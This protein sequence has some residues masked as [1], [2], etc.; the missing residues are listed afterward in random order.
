[1]KKT[2]WVIGSIVSV[3]AAMVGGGIWFL[4]PHHPATPSALT[5]VQWEALQYTVPQITTNT[6]DGSIVQATVVVQAVNKATLTTLTDSPAQVENA[7]VVTLNNVTSSII[8]GSGGTATLAKLLQQSLKPF[9]QISHVYFSQ[10]I[11]Q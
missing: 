5:P 3:T 7:L 4:E 1:M 6:N 9:G 8:A 2:V 11:I 10:L